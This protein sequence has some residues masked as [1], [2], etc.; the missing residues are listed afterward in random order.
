[1]M[2][3]NQV[4]KHPTLFDPSLSPPV[5]V[6]GSHDILSNFYPTTIVFKGIQFR[7][8]EHA[9][10][11][12]KAKYF[13]KHDLCYAVIKAPSASTAKRL[14][15]RLN[16]P[17]SGPRHKILLATFDSWNDDRLD[18][19]RTLLQIKFNSSSLFRTTLLGTGNKC[20]AHTVPDMYWGT[21]SCDKVS[22][23]QFHGLNMFGSLLM[24]LRNRNSSGG[25]PAPI[26]QS[27]HKIPSLLDLPIVAPTR[28]LRHF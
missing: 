9:Y 24:E 22:D 21:G 19:L 17:F 27:S 11:W 20:L 5:S 8:V 15:K 12:Q 28:P 4:L 2:S 23:T 10:Q 13:N 14:T 16:P 18:I 6:Q 26:S 3:V 25:S 1:M 7:S